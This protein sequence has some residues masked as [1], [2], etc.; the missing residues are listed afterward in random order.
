MANVSGFEGVAYAIGGGAAHSVDVF[1]LLAFA[2]TGGGEGVIEPTDLKVSAT[3]PTAN[4]QVHIST[5]AAIIRNRSANAFSQSYAVRAPAV[6]HLDV[7]AAGSGGANYLVVVRIEDPQFPPW[8]PKANPAVGPYVIPD[9]VP[10]A[11]GTTTA[12]QLG[13]SQ[14]MIA[15]ARID[16]PPNQGNITSQM[17]VPLRQLAQQ[18]SKRSIEAA[19]PTPEDRLNST[20]GRIWPDFRPKFYV[21]EWATGA[22][23]SGTISGVGIRGGSTQGVMTMVLD[24]PT[25]GVGGLR[26]RDIG[27]DFD[28][29]SQGGAR[30]P[31]LIAGGWNDIRELAGRE[32]E[33]RLEARS[34]NVPNDDLGDIWTVPGTQVRFDI[35]FFEAVL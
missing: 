12:R 20:I 17:I 4:N 10:C 21:P 6:T 25:I 2:A 24:G 11:P 33:V 18:R 9:I 30:H 34:T 14:S 29:P 27:Y 3:V 5:G 26:A 28:E 22:A 23:A 31:L 1:R 8:Q 35:E 16:V 13:L 19:V 7:P 32:V 15:L